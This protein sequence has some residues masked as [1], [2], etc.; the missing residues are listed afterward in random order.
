MVG[1]VLLLALAAMTIT[2]AVVYASISSSLPDPNAALGMGRDQSTTILDRNG[3]VLTRLYAEQNR[4]DRPLDKIPASL[5][6]AVI[7]TEDQ[8]FYEHAGVDPL[9][10]ARAV[11]TDV[12]LRRGA[13]GGS[14]ITQQYVKQAFVGNERSL[15]RKVAE[16]ML[17]N[18]VEK[19]YSKDQILELY[20]NTIYFGHGAYGVE[21]AAQAYFGKTVEKLSLPESAMIAGV[22]KSPGRYSPYLDRAAAKIRRD[23]VLGQMKAQ[24]FI[25]AKA[26]AEAAASPIKTS[27]LKSTAVAAPYFVE[28]IKDQLGKKYDQEQ[29]YRG[30]LTVRTTLDLVAQRAAEQAIAGSLNRKGD[31]SAAIVAVE[32]G[33]GA[34]IAMVGGR[35]FKTQQYN[36]AA[37]GQGRQPGSAFKPF[38]LATALGQG[39]SPEQTFESGPVKLSLSSQVWSVTGA[40]GGAKGPM[41]LRRATEESVNSVYAKLILDVGP[42]KVVATAEKMGLRKGMR[43]VPAIALGG[44]ETG[45]TPLEMA[46]AYATLAAQGRHADP[47]GITEVKDAEGHI[48]FAAK[49]HADDA[50]DPAVA[51]LTTDILQGV[52]SHGTGTAAAIGRPAAGKTGTTQEYRDAWFVGYTPQISAAVWV[53]YPQGQKAMTNVHGRQVTGGSFPAQIWARFMRAALLGQPAKEFVKPAGLKRE[54]VC[55]ETGLA[56]TQFCPTKGSELFLAGTTLSPC[57]KHAAPVSVKVPNLVGMTKEAAL[58]LVGRMKLVAKVVDGDVK[59]VSAGTVAAQTPTSG[60]AATPKTVVTITVSTGGVGNSAPTADYALPPRVKASEKAML[61]GSASKDDGKIVTWYWEFGDGATGSGM[62]VSHMWAAIGDYDVTLWVTDDRG[63]QAS[64]SKKLHVH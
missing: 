53:G 45:V 34:V 10:I 57:T 46:D 51:Y 16:A 8:R 27:G 3:R 60:S 59:G 21:S 32:P 47:F 22:I 49:A 52:I 20:L 56:A 14:T 9:G 35:D 25:T 6:Q 36:V 58:A 33:T 19:R 63:Q 40:A 43:P 44:L 26:F 15:R 41:R 39:I 37:Q 5:R 17:A 62:T 29:I 31:P 38:V 64:I 28:W 54:T 30:G 24:N 2:A 18:R 50:L 4:S 7:A 11:F 12:V 13:Q 42:E 23:T 1:L 55:L 61:D 48:L